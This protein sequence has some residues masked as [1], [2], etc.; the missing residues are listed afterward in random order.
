MSYQFY[1][2][3]SFNVTVN[4]IYG[5]VSIFIITPNGQNITRSGIKSQIEIVVPQTK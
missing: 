2:V 5:S 1:S 3:S 4:L